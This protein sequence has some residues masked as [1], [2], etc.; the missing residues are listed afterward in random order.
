[1]QRIMEGF[2]TAIQKESAPNQSLLKQDDLKLKVKTTVAEVLLGNLD[3]SEN[4][5]AQDLHA[6]GVH[7][8]NELKN[9]LQQRKEVNKKI[10]ESLIKPRFG[11]R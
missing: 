10:I 5:S 3:A 6:I 2:E 7:T 11:S 1:M 4:I 8:A 9:Y